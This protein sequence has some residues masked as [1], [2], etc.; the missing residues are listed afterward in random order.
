[1][2]HDRVT[3]FG[4]GPAALP[5]P[6]LEELRRD[7][8]SLPGVGMSIL[9]V[10]HRSPMFKGV[11]EETEANLRQLLAIPDDYRVLFLHGGASLQ[12]S[13]VAMNFLRGRSGADYLVTGSWGK[14]AV[15]E[16]AREGAVRLAW[17]GESDGFRRAPA[18]GELALGPDAVY[19]HYTSNETIQGVQFDSAP[20]GGEVPLVCDA[21]SD[22]LSRPIDV[23]AH[24]LVYAGAQKN[25]G[26][27]GVTIAV[28]RDAFL[29]SRADSLP[30]M[31]DYRVHADKGSAFNTP[32]V[33]A[34]YS[35][36]LVTRWLLSE[37]GDLAT[38]DRVGRER[39]ALL[40][41]AIDGSAGF[42]R[43]HAA[44][45]CRSR[46]NV[47]FRLP[48]EELEQR[49]LAEASEQGLAGLKGHR[50]VGGLRA[51]IYNAVPTAGIESLARFME[52]F[53]DEHSG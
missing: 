43:G 38:V 28:I 41:D 12:F 31:L 27:A 25:A 17:D 18:A 29:E 3:N 5:L 1:M 45:D 48:S 23:A 51:S 30:S 19:L 33:F 10:S 2:A 14:K 50:S 9:E 22:I 4:P 46:M 8:L 34:I 35:V 7:L 13:M 49:F 11:L 42:Y 39:A 6:V 21:S 47:T 37:F 52:A 15:K 32:P 16:A 24:G 36:L 20:A 26:P 53:R 40:Y 44:S